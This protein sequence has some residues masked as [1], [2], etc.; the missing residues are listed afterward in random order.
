MCI[1]DRDRGAGTLFVQELDKKRQGVGR[2]HEYSG[3]LRCAACDINYSEPV[4]NLFSF[5][6]PVGACETCRGFGRIMGIDYEQVIPDHSLT[7]RQGA[8]KVFRSPVYSES[9]RDILGY[10][11]SS[12]IPLDV[13]WKD[14][15]EDERAW[16]LEGEGNWYSCLL[17]TS[18][19]PRDRTRSR[20]PS[21]A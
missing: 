2:L 17:Y 21:S 19:S 6:S 1:R 13:A 12:G 4:S 7:L 11:E 3:G 10:A 16:V 8:I 5:N 20:M 15:S 14:L 18:P 9:Y